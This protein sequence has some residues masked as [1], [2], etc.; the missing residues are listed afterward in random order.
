[1]RRD[2]WAS[3]VSNACGK[4]S[5]TASTT[6]RARLNRR[7]RV[8][9]W[10]GVVPGCMARVPRHPQYTS[11]RGAESRGRA[12]EG[13]PGELGTRARA[14]FKERGG[15]RRQAILA[16][17]QAHERLAPQR[18]LAGCTRGDVARDWDSQCCSHSS[19][20]QSICM[21]VLVPVKVHMH[22]NSTDSV[23]SRS[24]G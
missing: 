23:K 7:P 22:A 20:C 14:A 13:A 12:A 10:G 18:L 17:E 8:W 1:M 9:R 16:H 19:E 15:Y 2:G 24:C 11:Q 4:E 5:R 6:K 3:I 21:P